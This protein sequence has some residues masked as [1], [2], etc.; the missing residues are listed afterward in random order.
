AG[1]GHATAGGS[2]GA[3]QTST[4]NVQEP[5]VDEPDEVKTNGHV[6]FDLARGRLWAVTVEGAPRIVGS[7]PAADA[8][9]LF[10]V[11]DR[12]VLLGHGGTG[13]QPQPAASAGGTYPGYQPK[14]TATI[15]D[16]SDPATMRV[17]SRLELEG[18]IAAARE[19]GGVA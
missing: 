10:L 1:S 2:S 3:P 17:V 7:L 6:L 5:G 19:V 12:A 4:T 16:V 14:A 8:G 11:G 15:V 18:G 9:E 13:A